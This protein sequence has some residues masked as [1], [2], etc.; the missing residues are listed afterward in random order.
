MKNIIIENAKFE[1]MKKNGVTGRKL[2]LNKLTLEIKKYLIREKQKNRELNRE[3]Y[4]NLEKIKDKLSSYEVAGA[5][6][7]GRILKVEYGMLIIGYKDPQKD[8]IYYLN[9]TLGLIYNGIIDINYQEITQEQFNKKIVFF[10][11]EYGLKESKVGCL[12]Q[13]VEFSKLFDSHCSSV[14][15][16]DII[17]YFLK[18]EKEFECDFDYYS[19]VIEKYEKIILMEDYE[20][21]EDEIYHEYLYSEIYYDRGDDKYYYRKTFDRDYFQNLSV[22]YDS[23]STSRLI[24]DLKD[25]RK[26]KMPIDNS[27]MEMIERE[28]EAIIKEVEKVEKSV[29][30]D[31]K[32]SNRNF[33]MER[34]MLFS[35]E[36]Y[37]PLK[38]D[39]LIKSL[40]Y[41]NYLYK[42]K[43]DDKILEDNKYY[44]REFGSISWALSNFYSN[45]KYDDDSI[46]YPYNDEPNKVS[47]NNIKDLWNLYV[48]REF[49]LFDTDFYKELKEKLS[50][51]TKREIDY[52]F[53]NKFAYYKFDL[54][55]V[56]ELK[57]ENSKIVKIS[58]EKRD[59][60][61][62]RYMIMVK[63]YNK[64]LKELYQIILDNQEREKD[65]PIDR[66]KEKRGKHDYIYTE[67]EKKIILRLK[68]LLSKDKENLGLS[69]FFGIYLAKNRYF[70][71]IEPNVEEGRVPLLFFV[72]ENPKSIYTYLRLMKI[73]Y[74]VLYYQDIIM[75]YELA[76]K[77]V[78][79]VTDINELK[80][81]KVME[82][83][84]NNF[85][86][87][88][89]QHFKDREIDYREWVDGLLEHNKDLFK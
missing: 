63:N 34:I 53:I 19:T 83:F 80:A 15:H 85:E 81:F 40:N 66:E 2:S 78:K 60:L 70:E 45:C 14:E 52:L 3:K 55:I 89:M 1:E 69:F 33:F 8:L 43:D 10:K 74:T 7:V 62:D 77:H 44:N 73:A 23:W 50:Y 21:E 13:V 5:Y 56:T 51:F 47:E 57:F 36:N 27:R 35:E 22:Y 86:P 24:V 32:K 46:N 12:Y 4:D 17:K 84:F 68:Q 58:Y 38:D 65:I 31:I 64:E 9:V 75:T 67:E 25:K 49:K 18:E 37:Q 59:I 48:Y 41:E 42:Y 71:T 61:K 30:K 28:T 16:F 79:D 29:K 87:Q 39:I 54:R 76:K 11:N 20:K 26:F 6:L 82:K 88:M 72:K